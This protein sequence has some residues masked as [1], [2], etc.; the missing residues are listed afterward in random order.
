MGVTRMV[1]E[2]D[3]RTRAGAVAI[4]Q[5]RPHDMEALEALAR[6][7][8][9]MAQAQT[10]GDEFDGVEPSPVT[11]TYDWKAFLHEETQGAK[12]RQESRAKSREKKQA[13]P[14]EP[15]APAPSVFY[16]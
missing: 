1:R 15:P 4:R 9:D 6:T 2:W 13:P 14:A 5:K 3:E 8:R 11:G 12:R 10:V 16:A 7:L